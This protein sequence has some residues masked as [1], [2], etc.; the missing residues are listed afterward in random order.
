MTYWNVLNLISSSQGANVCEIL[1]CITTKPSHEWFSLFPINRISN[2]WNQKRK[3]KKIEYASHKYIYVR[4]L[5]KRAHTQKANR[6]DEKK[7]LRNKVQH[8][9][10]VFLS[11]IEF[12]NF[13]TFAYHHVIRNE[14]WKTHEDF[15]FSFV[16]GSSQYCF[17]E[18]QQNKKKKWK[19][20]FFLR[21]LHA[22]AND[23]AM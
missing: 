11:D 18:K 6:M 16:I 9:S 17:A 3:K 20:I 1:K 19:W 4:S 22:N 21:R 10:W 2:S 23:N 5:H 12:C 7:N 14:I 8:Y 13:H 15:F